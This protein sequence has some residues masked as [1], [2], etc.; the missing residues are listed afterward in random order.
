MEVVCS[1]GREW[2]ALEWWIVMWS[3]RVALAY[4]GKDGQDAFCRHLE[5]L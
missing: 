1:T 2:L 5:I 4:S 3:G